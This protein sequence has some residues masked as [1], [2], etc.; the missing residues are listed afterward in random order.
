[1]KARKLSLFILIVVCYLFALC[2]YYVVKESKLDEIMEQCYFEGQKDYAI[3]DKRI[4]W[5]DQN[6]W[7][8]IKS[9][10]NDGS[11]PIFNP[12]LIHSKL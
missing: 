7:V 9:P 5:T 2:N 12:S 8:W 6:C 11:Q 1:M 4:E 10:W 3:G